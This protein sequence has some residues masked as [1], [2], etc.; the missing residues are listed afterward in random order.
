M[1]SNYQ[2]YYNITFLDDL[3]TYFPDIL[4]SDN[5]RFRSVND[6][7]DYIRSQTR[8]QFDL[9]SNA[10]NQ[11]NQERPFR[12]LTT[13]PLRNAPPLTTDEY[14]QYRISFNTE[15]II[16]PSNSPI[17]N[18]MLASLASIVN[19]L[20]PTT[21]HNRNFIDPVVVRPTQEQITSA[22]S[23]VELSNNNEVCAICQETM[24]DGTIRR[25]N[26]CRHTFHNTCINR[27]FTTNVRCPICRFDIRNI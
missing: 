10:Q 1:S 22:T 2:H 27:H 24:V 13:T 8:N 7:L 4:Y 5:N 19:I 25:I 18:D 26:H 14:V 12:Q 16:Q 23:I 20:Y 9:F 11:F 15:D 21:T 17:S 6:L 3:H